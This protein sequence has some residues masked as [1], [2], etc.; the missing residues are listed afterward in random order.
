MS[1]I[2]A[3]S[4]VPVEG[5]LDPAYVAGARRPDR[6]P[7]RPAAA[8]RARRRAPGSPGVDA[9]S[10]P[11]GTTHFVIGDAQGNVVSMTT[12]VESI[13]GSGR[14][15]DGFFL[16]NQM[17]DFSFQPARRAGPAGR[18]CGGARANARARR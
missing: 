10:E 11:A 16:N 9:T 1:A 3:F 6:R 4:P 8:R 18:Q 13:F 5:L 17:T 15:V 2:P 12:T 7:R 14:M